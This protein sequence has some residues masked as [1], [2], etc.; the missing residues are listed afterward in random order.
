MADQTSHKAIL[1]L[2]REPAETLAA[3]LSEMYWPPAEAIGLFDN[4]DGTWRVEATF[5]GKPDEATLKD[6]IG[7]LG[8]GDF[9]LS[10]E[11]IPDADWVSLSQAGLH[12][13]RAGRFL[14]HGSHDRD[15][16]HGNR[17]AIEIE[18]GQA[19]GTAHHGSTLG[20]LRAIDD[21]AKRSHFERV[22]DIGT[23]TGVLAIAAA[24][25]W[26]AQVIASDL[27]PIA[28]KTARE[29]VR[30]NGADAYVRTIMAD[31]LAHPLIRENSPYD[32]VIANIL[33]KPLIAMSH[34]I[35]R[36]LR[37]GGI[38]IL[39]GI[40]REQAGRVAAAYGAAGFTRLARFT[41]SDWVT[42]ALRHTR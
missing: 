39:S 36:A 30:K 29:N 1:S 19:F 12:P 33:A 3:A 16:A 42:L 20:C 40:T 7:S 9:A 34:D 18:A 13:V 15:R 21:L 23:G 5:S 24:R 27:D 4:E 10:F 37:P 31:G 6:F 35:A 26:R 25:V 38:V 22:L 41:I 32:L 8:T 14:I 28:Q 11:E 2:P 17:W